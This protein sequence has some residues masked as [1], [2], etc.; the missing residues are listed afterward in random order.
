[1]S[2]TV[3][4]PAQVADGYLRSESATYLTAAH[5]GGTLTAFDTTPDMLLGQFSAG[6]V[7]SVYECFFSFDVAGAIPAGATLLNVAI[8]YQVSDIHGSPVTIEAYEY[9]WGAALTTADWVQGFNIGSSGPA[10]V[11]YGQVAAANGA[12]SLGN[13]NLFDAVQDAYDTAVPVRCITIA[14]EQR[15]G[16]A[17]VNNC[18]IL[19][20]E[21]GTSQSTSLVVIYDP[22]VPPVIGDMALGGL[23]S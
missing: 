9:D 13:S 3:E 5:F 19:A 10:T 12:R 1:M 23:H 8:R 14:Q 11:L 17:N 4:I 22:P 16:D 2:T 20:S 18:K 6:G 15:L 7:W 21:T